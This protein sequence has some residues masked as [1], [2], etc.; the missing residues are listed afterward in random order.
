MIDIRQPNI[1]AQ[2]TQEQVFQMRSYLYQLSQQ[3][4]WAFNTV[5]LG[6][7]GG[8]VGASLPQIQV[9]GG[10]QVDAAATFAAIKGLIIKSADIVNAYYDSISQKLDG[11]YVAQSEFGE[12]REETSNLIQGNS[13][14]ISQLYTNNRTILLNVEALQGNTQNLSGRVDQLDADAKGAS[15]RLDNLEAN[16]GGLSDTVEKLEKD[17]QGVAG[18]VEKLQKDTQS[19]TETVNGLVAATVATN[20]YIRT[21][22]LYETDAGVPVYGLE[23]GQTNNV[24]GENVF[25]KFARFSADRLSFY[26]RNDTEVA[27]ISDYKLYINTAEITGSLQFGS[28]FK[29]AY[30]AGA[31][32][33]FKWMGG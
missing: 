26:D 21:G 3:L 1:T 33:V 29:V 14:N 15:G 18:S 8:N 4:Q 10:G 32:L 7:S 19:V 5:S 12:Y 25:S 23:V 9:T 28:K 31:G 16:T 27:Y 22:L 13:T 11:Q 20:A 24:N 6:E 17:A 2:N 30:Q